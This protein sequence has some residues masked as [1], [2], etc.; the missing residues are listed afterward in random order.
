MHDVRR[1]IK[2]Q[3]NWRSSWQAMVAGV[4]VSEVSDDFVKRVCNGE[5]ILGP[6]RSPGRQPR[7]DAS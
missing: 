3:L 7:S 1:H 6:A 4:A 5:L 2:R